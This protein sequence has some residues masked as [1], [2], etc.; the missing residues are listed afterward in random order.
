MSQENRPSDSGSQTL[1]TS[2]AQRLRRSIT[3]GDILPG[4]KLRLDTLR[5][6]FGVSLSPL[7]EALSR[8]SAEGYVV[9]EDQRGYRVAPVSESNFLEVMALRAEI[10]PFGLRE[11]IRQGDDR[12]EGE[13]VASLY[14][15]TKIE[16]TTRSLESVAGWEAAH[17]AFHQQLL[18]G[19]GMP[20]L[21]QFSSTLHDLGDRYRRL[22]LEH[23]PLDRDVGDEHARICNATLARDADLACGL[24]REHIERT[25]QIVLK[26]LKARSEPA[27]PQIVSA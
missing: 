12:W 11:A 21:M 5:A 19:C 23:H 22:F 1:A 8:L 9:M 6:T 2:L 4:E 7:R 13:V 16:R 15:L 20:I 26:E 3:E 17:R 25:G 18:V 27:A 14:R 10:E 24:L